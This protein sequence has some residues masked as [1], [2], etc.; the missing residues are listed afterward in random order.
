MNI[1]V[2]ELTPE[3][4]FYP[5]VGYPTRTG[6]P[7]NVHYSDGSRSEGLMSIKQ[8]KELFAETIEELEKLL[9]EAEVSLLS[10]PED[11]FNEHCFCNRGLRQ[12]PNGR[13]Y[14]PTH[15]YEYQSSTT[16]MTR[17]EA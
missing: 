12:T 7:S 11:G 1:I 4:I 14:C 16:K 9:T 2:I 6:F 15:G 13:K 3:V 10:D 17:G 5:R 8:I